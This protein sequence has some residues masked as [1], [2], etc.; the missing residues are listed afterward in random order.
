MISCKECGWDV[1]HAA[2]CSMGPPG[3]PV[4]PIPIVETNV[5]H[6]VTPADKDLKAIAEQVV[7]IVERAATLDF[8]NEER[9]VLLEDLA[10]LAVL[11]IEDFSRA[12]IYIAERY[13]MAY[14]KSACR[15]RCHDGGDA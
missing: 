14:A 8:A 4:E 3:A 1:G 7:E 6:F 13:G 11:Y 5:N 9:K 2:G 15:C 10:S 12:Y